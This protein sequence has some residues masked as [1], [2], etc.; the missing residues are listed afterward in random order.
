MQVN[1]RV[2]HKTTGKRGRVVFLA[3]TEF[4]DDYCSVAWDD[5]PDGWPA[6][7]VTRRDALELI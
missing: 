2:Q 6:G 7:Y 3:L 1:A 4:S 5:M